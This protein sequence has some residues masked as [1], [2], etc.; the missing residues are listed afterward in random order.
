M[1]SRGEIQQFNNNVISFVSFLRLSILAPSVLK[2]ETFGISAWNGM[3]VGCKKFASEL[4]FIQLSSQSLTHHC[5]GRRTRTHPHV[6]I[7]THT[8]THTH[9]HTVI[10]D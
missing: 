1:D 8:H 9:T 4:L 7:Y 2:R 3:Q 5:E 10:R 6:H